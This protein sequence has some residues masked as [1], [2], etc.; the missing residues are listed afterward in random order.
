MGKDLIKTLKKNIHW[1]LL[2]LF[3]IVIV[4]VINNQFKNKESFRISAATV[5]R[6]LAAPPNPDQ[7]SIRDAAAWGLAGLAAEARSTVAAK[8]NDTQI[9]FINTMTYDSFYK[10]LNKIKKNASNVSIEIIH[11][12]GKI[13][14]TKDILELVNQIL[15]DLKTTLTVERYNQIQRRYIELLKGNGDGFSVGGQNDDDDDDEDDDGELAQVLQR[16]ADAVF[17]F[18]MGYFIVGDPDDVDPDDVDIDIQNRPH[19]I[20]YVTFIGGFAYLVAEYDA[21]GGG[22]AL[23][24]WFARLRLG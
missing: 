18:F 14:I 4:I 5:D 17:N 21:W 19:F 12:K 6:A 10:L 23:A 16:Q 20:E 13:D 1:I 22:I 11:N 15:K 8:S 9:N 3:T 24:I 7:P 2:I